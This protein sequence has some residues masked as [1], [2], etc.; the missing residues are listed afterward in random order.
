MGRDD[1]RDAL[2]H[3]L[4]SESSS[5]TLILGGPGIGKT[6]LTKAIAHHPDVAARFGG[7][8]YFVEL[9]NEHSARDMQAAII[10]A[11]GCDPQYGFQAAL[12]T[13]QGK[14]SLLILDNL[15]TPW[16]SHDQRHA[17]EQVL[18][19]LAAIPGVAILA[20]FRGRDAVGGLRWV[21]HPLTEL[22]RTDAIQLFAL[23]AGQWALADPDLGNFTYTLGGIPLAIEFVARRAYGRSSLAALWK[24]WERIGVKLAE[25]PDFDAGR[26]TSV[27]HS[28]EL[29]LQSERITP[30]ALRLFYILGNLPDGLAHEDRD[31]LIGEAAFDAEERLYR[32]GLVIERA[33]RIVLLPPVRDHALRRTQS[34]CEDDTTW[35]KHF[36]G[37]VRRLGE[38][39]GTMRGDG[40]LPRL[41]SEYDNIEAAFRAAIDYDLYDE[42]MAALRGFANYAHLAGASTTIFSDYAPLCHARG[43]ILGE[44]QCLSGMGDQHLGGWDLK[45]AREAFERALPFTKRWV[46]WPVR[47]IAGEVLAIRSLTIPQS[48]MLR[49]NIRLRYLGRSKMRWVKLIVSWNS[50]FSRPSAR[51]TMRPKAT[52]AKRCPSTGKRTMHSDKQIVSMALVKSHFAVLIPRRHARS[53]R[54][55]SAFLRS[56]GTEVWWV[57]TQKDCA[58]SERFATSYFYREFRSMLLRAAGTQ[59]GST[60]Q[61]RPASDR[62]CRV[63]TRRIVLSSLGSV[64]DRFRHCACHASANASSAGAAPDAASSCP[65]R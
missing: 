65:R 7:H 34:S 39:I 63:E 37:L 49:L 33:G 16:L 40:A 50:P 1:E 47:R 35:I 4:A 22:P 43:D 64:G 28:I 19:D 42:A 3:I 25:H 29:S 30:P 44:A 27:P 53:L 59:G 60:D 2:A 21:E 36:I 13:L 48:G 62:W 5:A 61:M 24:E 52:L 12:S 51:T 17:T 57:P 38:T 45:S 32:A 46:I 58:S 15:E 31:A 41:S 8:R 6:E 26:L 23:I 9:E 20:S 14:Q 10:R 54:K 55:P 11:L 18:A 56:S